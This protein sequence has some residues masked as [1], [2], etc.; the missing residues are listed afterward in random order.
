[1]PPLV[2]ASALLAVADAGAQALTA[3]QEALA[4]YDAVRQHD[5]SR[6][7]GF[8]AALMQVQG[9]QVE[10]TYQQCLDSLGIF[11]FCL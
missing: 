11:I 1:M 3:Y 2:E 6:L 9:Y 7:P 4:A 5:M 10:L 8:K